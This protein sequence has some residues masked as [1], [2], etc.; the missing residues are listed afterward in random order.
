MGTIDTRAVSGGEVLLR[1]LLL[2]LTHQTFSQ[3]TVYSQFAS[4][5][6]MIITTSAA[7]RMFSVS[8]MSTG[9]AGRPTLL[10]KLTGYQEDVG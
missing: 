1:N 2:V 4:C 3:D 5:F 10:I 6:D 9:S 7:R 8:E